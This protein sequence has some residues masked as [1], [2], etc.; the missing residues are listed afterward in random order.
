MQYSYFEK[1]ARSYDAKRKKQYRHMLKRMYGSDEEMIEAIRKSGDPNIYHGTPELGAKKSMLT[2]GAKVDKNTADAFGKGTYFADK[3]RALHYTR[4]GP[5]ADTTPDGLIRFKR[6]SE[7]KGTK[8]TYGNINDYKKV[9]P[10]KVESKLESNLRRNMNGAGDDAIS[11]KKQQILNNAKNKNKLEAYGNIPIKNSKTGE[12]KNKNLITDYMG[13]G[14]KH[15]LIGTKDIN[16]NLLTSVTDKGVEG[17]K[18]PELPKVDTAKW[19]AKQKAKQQIK[20]KVEQQNPNPTPTVESVKEQIKDNAKKIGT[21]TSNPIPPTPKPNPNPKVDGVKE[22]IKNKAFK[23]GT[24]GK[25]GIGLG[26][27]AIGGGL[28][29]NHYRKKREQQGVM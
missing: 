24:K 3:D 18:R 22:G 17:L 26:T 16:S 29:Y 19:E 13:D 12:I 7:L 20:K 10:D 28:L 2:E 14:Q 1:L 21:G 25:I 15:Q 5:G 8:V 4:N 27:A 23:L 6:P 11:N 9:T